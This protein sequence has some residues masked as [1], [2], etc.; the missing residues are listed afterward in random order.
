MN[1]MNTHYTYVQADEHACIMGGY[2][3]YMHASWVGIEYICM[4]S[5]KMCEDI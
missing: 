3:V 4:H 5:Y 1:E 2:R